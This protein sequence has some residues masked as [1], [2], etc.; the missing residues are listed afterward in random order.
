MELMAEMGELEAESSES[1][2][3]SRGEDGGLGREDRETKC[4]QEL[5]GAARGISSRQAWAAGT[6][7]RRTMPKAAL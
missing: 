2:R 4:R 1:R 5:S 7:Q 6:N 3:G